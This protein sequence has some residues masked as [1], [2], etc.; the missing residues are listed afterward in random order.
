M[1]QA[2]VSRNNCV[3]EGNSVQVQDTDRIHKFI[4]TPP[5]IHV[6]AIVKRIFLFSI[7][8][9]GVIHK[10]KEKGGRDNNNKTVKSKKSSLKQ[11]IRGLLKTAS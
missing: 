5:K 4:F 11:A 10:A 8:S 2:Q 7:S 3:T 1:F 9:L 6:K